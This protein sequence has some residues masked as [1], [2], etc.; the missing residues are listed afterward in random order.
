MR[1]LIIGAGEVGYHIATRLVRERHDVVVVDHTPDVIAR[2]QEEMDVMA[3]EGPGS[4]PETLERAGIDQTE[5]VIAATHSDEVNIVACL[6]A[7]QYGVPQCIARIHD[8]DIETSPLAAAGKRIGID[9]MINPS[10]AVA[11]EIQRL[12]YMP[13]ADEAAE[14]FEGR[15]QLISIRVPATAPIVQ[16]RIKEV[17]ARFPGALPGLVAA[18]QRG[19]KT[20]IPR[21]ETIIEAGD[22]LLIIGKDQ[23][24]QANLHLLGLSSHRMKNLLIIGGG[25]VG[26]QVVQLLS[27]DTTRYNIKILERHL[28][29]CRELST[30]LPHALVLNGDATDLKVLQEEGIRNMDGVIVVTDDDGTN[31]IAA[32]LA[33]T[34]GAHEV[35]TLVKRPD[36]IS[37][38]SALGIDAAISPRLVTADA[39]LR[40]LRRGQVLSM[41]TSTSTE[42]ETL[43]ME[44]LPRARIVGR[45]LHK[46]N[47]PEGIIIGA[48]ARGDTITIPRGDTVIEAYD[49]VLVFA[50]PKVVS[51]AVRLLGG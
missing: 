42:A 31:L 22:H 15:V 32:L 26:F 10:R 4:R 8:G 30:R 27:R 44:A 20:L 29:R 9:L 16:Q 12:I 2:V 33:K 51:R 45:P 24:L 1:I 13:G 3:F 18:I 46:V 50:L 28:Q 35:I 17:G 47:F 40:Y 25:Q 14:F 34:H 11:E 21:G 48:V 7:R 37:L 36:L 6:L 19:K 39:M 38:V 5:L 41:F 43:E 23:H 49:R